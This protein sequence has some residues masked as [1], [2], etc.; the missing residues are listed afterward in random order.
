MCFSSGGFSTYCSPRNVPL[1]KKKKLERKT[2]REKSAG[3]QINGI[4]PKMFVTSIYILFVLYRSFFIQPFIIHSFN[5]LFLLISF[6]SLRFNYQNLREGRS[7]PKVSRYIIHRWWK[8]KASRRMESEKKYA[9]QRRY[10]EQIGVRAATLFLL[11]SFFLSTRRFSQA[12]VHPAMH[13]DT[14]RKRSHTTVPSSSLSL[15]F[16][17]PGH[18]SQEPC[19]ALCL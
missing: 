2:A 10:L 4:N 14:W 8:K 19:T 13:A 17:H 1:K 3:Y 15:S 18:C 12:H 5:L 11:L 16:F 9:Q 6:D 7:W